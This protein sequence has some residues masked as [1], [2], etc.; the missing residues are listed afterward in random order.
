MIVICG[1]KFISKR[2]WYWCVVCVHACMSVCVHCTHACMYVYSHLRT[3]VCMCVYLNGIWF[4]SILLFI[5]KLKNEKNYH[6]RN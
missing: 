6:N 1:E 3:Y 2:L 5:E 4:K